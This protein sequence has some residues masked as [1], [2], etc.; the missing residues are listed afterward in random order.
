MGYGFEI[1]KS[2]GGEDY[3]ALSDN[4]RDIKMDNSPGRRL[5]NARSLPEAIEPRH[6]GGVRRRVAR[7][8]DAPLLARYSAQTVKREQRRGQ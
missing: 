3:Q 7:R 6:S 2:D 5:P 4:V 8:M 1:I